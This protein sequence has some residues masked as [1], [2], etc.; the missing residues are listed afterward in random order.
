MITHGFDAK[1]TCE[2]IIGDGCGGGRIFT[3]V[4]ETLIAYD[5]YTKEKM[6]LLEKIKNALS[7][8]K[9]DCMICITCRDEVIDFDLSAMKRVTKEE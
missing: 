6:Q 4:D 1:L 3:I 8:A 9:S 2:G 5:P 7:I